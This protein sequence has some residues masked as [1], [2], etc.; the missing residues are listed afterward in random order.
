MRLRCCL[1]AVVN[2]NNKF[3]VYVDQSLIHSGSLLEDMTSVTVVV[4]TV[5]P[6]LSVC[7]SLCLSVCL[8]VLPLLRVSNTP[9]NPVNH[10]EI[11]IACWKLS[12][13]V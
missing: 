13:S 3:E 6:C 8:S 5:H 7:L 11:C 10:L 2:P 1:C 4:I 9:E 12:D